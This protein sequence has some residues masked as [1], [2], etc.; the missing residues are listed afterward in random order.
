MSDTKDAAG[1]LAG[2][3]LADEIVSDERERQALSSDVYGSGLTAALVLRPADAGRLAAAIAMLADRGFGIV[4]RGGGMSYTGGYT[5]SVQRCVIVDLSRLNRIV[6]VSAE[7]LFV[8]VECGVTWKQL[9]LHLDALGLRLPFFG[10]FSGAQATVGGGLSNGALFFGTARYGTA[11][12][13]VLGMEVILADGRRLRTGQGGFKNV[14]KPFYR[15]YGPDLTGLFCHDCGALGVKTEAT[16]RL[17]RKPEYTG[18][19]SFVFDGMAG[20]GRALSEIAR[21]GA[22]EELYVFDPQSTRKNLE[23]TDTLQSVK[24]L[25]NVVR[26]ERSLLE[27]LRQGAKLAAA[28]RNFIGPEDYSVHVVCAARTAAALEADLAAVR[29]ASANLS[30]REIVDSIPRTVRAGLF[31]PPDGVLGPKGDRWAALNAKVAHSDGAHIIQRAHEAMREFAP[32]FAAHNVWM[33]H[34]LIAVGNQAFSFEPVFHWFDE[35]LPMHERMPSEAVL[36]KF[37]RPTANLAAR[38]V[39]ARARARMLQVFVE[40]GAASNQIG[41]TYPYLEAMRPETR[42]LVLQLKSALDPQ[43]RMNPGVLGL[44]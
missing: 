32:E 13:N 19:A 17:I 2:V 26:A 20:A 41:R 11:A 37:E 23:A 8:T 12:D 25:A 43:G 4:P 7:D 21:T 40:L 24:A 39:V 9:H 10:T 29:K 15:T 6:A 5:P 1:L 42:Q 16:F 18:F 31:P 38:D 34:L 44:S 28:G 35:W 14:S 30:G 3:L 27:G 33:S 22:A 36:R